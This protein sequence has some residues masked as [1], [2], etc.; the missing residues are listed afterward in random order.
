[1]WYKF[2][3]MHGPGHQG[4]SEVYLWFPKKLSNQE[5]ESI[6]ERQFGNWDNVVAY[7]RLVSKPPKSYALNQIRKINEELANYLPAK[8]RNLISLKREFRKAAPKNTKIRTHEFALKRKKYWRDEK[9]ILQFKMEYSS[10][11]V[12]GGCCNN[13][14]QFCCSNCTLIKEAMR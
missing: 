6:C 8:I 9:D 2:W 14:E 3:A 4:H 1:M 13:K 7:S 10:C 5:K 12:T 11:K